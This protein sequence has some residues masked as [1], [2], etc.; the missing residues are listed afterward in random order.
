MPAFY[1]IDKE[2]RVV[3]MASGVFSLADAVSHTAKLSKD[4]DFDARFHK[5]RTSRRSQESTFLRRMYGCW[6]TAAHSRHDHAALSSFLTMC[7][8]DC[9]TCSGCSGKTMAKRASAFF[10]A[11]KKP[12]IGCSPRARAPNHRKSCLRWFREGDGHTRHGV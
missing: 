4:P 1:K 3:S 2:R 11:L 6:L 12:W 9:D 7:Y 5:S 10:R 8:S